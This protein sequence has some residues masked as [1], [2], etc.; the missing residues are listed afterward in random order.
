MSFDAEFYIHQI[1]KRLGAIITVPVLRAHPAAQEE[2]FRTLLIVRAML[3]HPEMAREPQGL[4]WVTECFWRVASN[5]H[6]RGN[7]SVP[8]YRLSED[9]G[10]DMS[11]LLGEVRE[12][13]FHRQHVEQELHANFGG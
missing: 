9:F 11:E 5:R 13:F 7:G 6:P 3:E 10:I 8:L 12:E 4:K 2:A 1:D